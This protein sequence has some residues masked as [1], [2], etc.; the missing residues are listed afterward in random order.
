MTAGDAL[1]QALQSLVDG[2]PLS[3]IGFIFALSLVPMVLLSVTSFVKLS[4]VFGLLRNAIGAQ[5]IPSSAI[6]SLLS[7]VL[8]LHVMRPVAVEAAARIRPLLERNSGRTSISTLLPPILEAAS[9]PLLEFLSAHSRAEERLF[10][11]RP[12]RSQ[13]SITEQDKG[14]FA[15]PAHRCL[16]PGEG[17]FTL[18][19]AF[20]LSELRAA[21]SF[22]F[23]L[24]LPF[25]VID[26]VVANF[27]VG[28]GMTMVSPVT[29]SLPVK[30]L[31]FVVSDAWFRICR[32]L[33]LSY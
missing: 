23:V 19:P 25:L 30:I 13:G 4:V 6:T 21:F 14:C 24:F 22:G 28:V 17:F 33:V 20:V 11:L 5:Q 9:A 31:V 2:S 12:E 27:L 18:I 8:T 7:L 10:F 15:D 3:T 1:S 26:L 16:I 32:S 29:I